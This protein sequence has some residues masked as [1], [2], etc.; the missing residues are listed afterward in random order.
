MAT[1]AAGHRL[2]YRSTLLRF[3]VLRTL[4]DMTPRRA[5]L[6]YA[7]PTFLPFSLL[8]YSRH[9]LAACHVAAAVLRATTWRA[10]NH[11]TKVK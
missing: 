10:P 11:V 1:T 9:R 6:P 8:S 7:I 2:S 4:T 3:M 5:L